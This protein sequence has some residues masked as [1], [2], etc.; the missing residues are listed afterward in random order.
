MMHQV[1]AAPGC[2]MP[3]GPSLIE[4]AVTATATNGEAM[5]LP[6]RPDNEY[7]N[8]I[9][10]NA[11]NPAHANHKGE[12]QRTA[13]GILHPSLS[14][15]ATSMNCNDF[16]LPLTHEVPD[17]NTDIQKLINEFSNEQDY[18]AQNGALMVRLAELSRVNIRLS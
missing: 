9:E 7:V 13:A 4:P 16:D 5:H 12:E 15:H 3:G 17:G 11:E 18:K 10:A 14:P 8:F 2:G 1:T 6:F